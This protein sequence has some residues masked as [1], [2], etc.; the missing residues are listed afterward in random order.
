LGLA[1][2][3]AAAHIDAFRR[4][5]EELLHKQYLVYDDDAAL[6][7]TSQEALRDLEQLFEADAREPMPPAETGKST[8]DSALLD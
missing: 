4:H 7:Q 6:V 1:P 8:P 3:T 2:E 5:D